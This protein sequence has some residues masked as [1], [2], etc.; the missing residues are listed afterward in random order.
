MLR[1]TTLAADSHAIEAAATRPHLMEC[2]QQKLTLL[3]QAR[4]EVTDD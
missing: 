1:I 3:G 2:L 4:I